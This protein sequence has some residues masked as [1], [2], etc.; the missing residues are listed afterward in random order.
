MEDPETRPA[1]EE[2]ARL[3]GMRR[4]D[5]PPQRFE[6]RE[7]ALVEEPVGLAVASPADPAARR[8]GR[9]PV[10]PEPVQRGRVHGRHV[11]AH[12]IEDDRS[13]G[14]PPV[15]PFPTRGLV[16]GKPLVIPPRAPD[17]PPGVR[18]HPGLQPAVE[19]LPAPDAGQVDPGR[20]PHRLRDVEVV[21][22]E[23]REEET[24]GEVDP[25]RSRGTFVPEPG[26]VADGDDPPVLDE[27]RLVEVAA[28]EHGPPVEE[29][30]GRTLH[31]GPKRAER[32]EGRGSERD[33]PS[34]TGRGSGRT[35]TGAAGG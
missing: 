30:G 31:G 34:A 19:L 2:R 22:G 8:V 20:G 23:S 33:R 29:G 18:I 16:L 6:Q 21:V 24:P 11:P 25:L 3:P 32:K 12:P 5:R 15:E 13:V 7:G 14:D 35:R 27:E 9:S 28:R 4:K 1:I 26:S 17:G 10:D